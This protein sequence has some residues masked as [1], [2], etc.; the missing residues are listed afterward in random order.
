MSTTITTGPDYVTSALSDGTLVATTDSYGPDG[1]LADSARYV[2]FVVYGEG[3]DRWSEELDIDVAR[4]VPN[5]AALAAQVAEQAAT[6]TL[7]A[8]WAEIV[9][10]GPKVGLYF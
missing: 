5:G 10:D 3:E 9:I 6:D 2:A 7:E 1:R 4:S 8:G